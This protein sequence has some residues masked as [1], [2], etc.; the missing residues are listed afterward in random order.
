MTAIVSPVH[1]VPSAEWNA[2][3]GSDDDRRRAILQR[4]I[5]QGRATAQHLLQSIE[6]DQPR[7]QIVRAGALGFEPDRC[8]GIQIRVGDDGYIPTEFALGQIAARARVPGPYLRELTAED[9]EPWRLRLAAQILRTHYEHL[10]SDRLLLRSVRGQ[11]RGWLSD[12]YRRLDSR[13]LV[14][15]LATEATQL[16]AVPID[17][18][19][20]ETRVALKLILPQVFEPVPGEFVAYGGEWSNSDFGNGVHSFRTFV[21]RV[22]C[23]NGMTGEN[24]LKQV[25][26]GTRLHED[27][28]LSDRTY[29]LDTATSASMLRDIVRRTFRNGAETL[30]RAIRAAHERS[31]SVVQ[32]AKSTRNL[33]KNVQSSIAAAFESPDIINLPV[34][35]T[36]WRASNA[37]SWVARNTQDAE[38]R[39]DLERTAGAFV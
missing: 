29:R 21:L 31:T 32:L 39:L 19:A 2:L 17:G 16:G 3:T 33:P 12:R 10:G 38:L 13:P 25:H 27:L 4:R 8:H 18:V 7:D 30:A 24:A 28:E 34:G 6:R 9:A 36:A 1:S 37:I 22:I 11:L 5:D 20:T 26:L 23:L 15:A 35:N 14:D